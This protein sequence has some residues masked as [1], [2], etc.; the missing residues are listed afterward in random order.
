ML[1]KCHE[2]RNS[3]IFPNNNLAIGYNP[4]WSKKVIAS[5]GP[6]TNLLQFPSSFL[7]EYVKRYNSKKSLEV[8]VEYVCGHWMV[9]E[10]NII[11]IRFK[12]DAQRMYSKEDVEELCRNAFKA[13]E[14]YRTGEHIYF[15]QIH[16]NENAWIK[17]N[18][19]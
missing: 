14:A 6:S 16:P 4:E 19:K 5:T 1:H 10:N 12:E 9:H 7:E 2:I 18:L 13:G 11:F 15:K 8:E 17:E 3:W